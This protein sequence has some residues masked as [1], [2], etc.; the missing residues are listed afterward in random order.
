[1]IKELFAVNVF[2]GQTI[3]KNQLIQAEHGRI[4]SLTTMDAPQNVPIVQYLSPG[5][6]DLQIN[7]GN[8]TFFTQKPTVESVEDIDRSCNA[9]GTV[10]TLPALTTSPIANIKEGISAIRIFRENHSNTGVLGMH[11]EGPFI[12]PE[13]RGGHPAEYVQQPTDD[14]LKELIENGKYIIKLMTIAPEVFKPS[15]IAMLIEAGITLSVGH[16]NATYPQA[17]AAFDMGIN[18]VT[19][20]YNAMSLFLPKSPGVVGAV[21]DDPRIYT[22]IILDGIHCDYAAARIAWKLKKDKLFLVSDALFTGKTMKE[23]QWRGIHIMLE[24][25]TYRNSEGNLNGAAI[26]LGDAVRN[27]VTH[28]GVPI[29]EAIEMATIRPAKALNIDDKVG[30][31]APGYPARFTIFD[32]ALQNFEALCLVE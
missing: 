29:Q 30:K 12:S 1:M 19:H 23:F 14:I 15:Q 5:F 16:S 17:K 2:D 4:L 20:F 22:P 18:L 25:G 31:I 28:V 24:N 8:K 7:G 13:K 9:L 11:L 26:S 6:I 10:W 27:A 3:L 32:K 21:F